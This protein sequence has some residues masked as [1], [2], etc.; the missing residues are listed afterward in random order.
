V[1][2]AG[3]FDVG[4]DTGTPVIDD[5]KLPFKYEGTLKLLTVELE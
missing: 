3:S 1:R 2:H 4:A 5:Y